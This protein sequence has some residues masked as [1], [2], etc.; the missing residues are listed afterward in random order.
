MGKPWVGRIWRPPKTGRFGILCTKTPIPHPDPKFL[1]YPQAMSG[2]A[3]CARTALA[4]V[5]HR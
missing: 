5:C 3:V 2:V 1:F 4:S